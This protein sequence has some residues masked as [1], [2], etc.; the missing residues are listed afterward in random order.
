LNLSGVLWGPVTVCLKQGVVVHGSIKRGDF[1][2]YA[3]Y[4]G[5]FLATFRDD[6]SVPSSRVSNLGFFWFL[7]T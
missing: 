4:S 1:E 2:N 7:D 6:L 5:N 3:A